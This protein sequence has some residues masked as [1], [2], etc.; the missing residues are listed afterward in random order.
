MFCNV[1]IVQGNS[2][3]PFLE[4]ILGIMQSIE[5]I[6]TRQEGILWFVLTN[7]KMAKKLNSYY[8]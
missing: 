5:F 2:G 8:T 7:S 6:K 3:G 4:F 1:G